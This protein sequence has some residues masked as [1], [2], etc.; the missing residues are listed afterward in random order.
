MEKTNEVKHIYKCSIPDQID[1]YWS[2]E[3]YC[4]NQPG[5]ITCDYRSKEKYNK[6][7]GG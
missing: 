6:L 1:C 7:G 2:K 4:Y 5:E 3:G